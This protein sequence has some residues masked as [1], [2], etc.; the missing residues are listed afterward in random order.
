M[1]ANRCVFWFTL[2]AMLALAACAPAAAP[3]PESAPTS[4][5]VQ[6]QSD[7]A[8]LAELNAAAGATEASGALQIGESVHYRVSQQM[9]VVND[10][11]GADS[12]QNLW[13][14]LIQTRS[15]YQQ[16]HAVAITPGDYQLARDEYGNLYAE[17]DFSAIQPGERSEVRLEYEVEVRRVAVDLGDCL[18]GPPGQVASQHTQAELYI[19]ANNPQV[20]ALSAELAAGG[21]TACAQARAFYDYTAEN[22]LYTFN[23]GNWGAQAALGLMGSDCT[24]Y[25]SLFAA[26]SRAAGIPARYFEGLRYGPGDE[27][28]AEHAWAEFYAPGAG[29]TP[30]DAT[31]GR[32]E[33]SREQYFARLPASHIIVTEG[34]NPSTLRGG[35]Y[36]A[37]LYWAAGETR[38]RVVDFAWSLRPLSGE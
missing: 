37:H 18:G 9:S 38:L 14:A 34:R 16:V 15:P 21:E 24:E 23:A 28:P 32:F 12:K 7:A 1:L 2:L 27:E 10:G 19:E 20:R 25:A 33:H 6:P 29:W 30:V 5:A 26:L 4:A 11:P 17:F 13:V 8:L 22:L 36:I 35:S 31:L 3:V